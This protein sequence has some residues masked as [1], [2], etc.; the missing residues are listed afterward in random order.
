MRAIH[1]YDSYEDKIRYYSKMGGTRDVRPKFQ[2]SSNSSL[3]VS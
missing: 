2:K 3:K 1:D